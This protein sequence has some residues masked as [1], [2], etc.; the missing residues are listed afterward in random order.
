MVPCSLSKGLR[1]IVRHLCQ[2][3]VQSVKMLHNCNLKRVLSACL[4]KKLCQ[5][6]PRQMTTHEFTGERG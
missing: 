3:K 6:T 5:I 2:C 1:T 4:S